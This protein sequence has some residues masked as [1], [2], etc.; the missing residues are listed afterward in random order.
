MSDL[1][2]EL[3]KAAKS[4]RLNHVSVG[5]IN[6]KWSASYRGVENRD[7]RIVDHDDIVSALIGAL[8]GRKPPEPPEPV[9]A[10]PPARKK[11]DFEGML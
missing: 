7:G 3:R 11:D 10:K 9:K 6:G 1:E 4:G 8:N 2:S 5:F